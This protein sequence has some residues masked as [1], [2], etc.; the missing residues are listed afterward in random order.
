[1][2]DSSSLAAGSIVIPKKITRD[3]IRRYVKQIVFIYGDAV[4]HD[5]NGKQAYEARGEPNAYAVPTK[6]CKCYNDDICF[7]KDEAFETYNKSIIDKA[8][9]SIPKQKSIILFP[10][11]GQGFNEMPTRCPKT[12]W[13]LLHK[14]F[15]EFQLA[16]INPEALHPYTD[17]ANFKR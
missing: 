11:I 1:M 7:F 6:I 17:Y 14:L 16:L 2:E 5:G 9:S 15:Q 10:K 12:Y 3:F 13:Y 8:L 4:Y